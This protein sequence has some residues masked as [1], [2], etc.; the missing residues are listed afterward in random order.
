[1]TL[2]ELIETLR[3]YRII[4]SACEITVTNPETKRKERRPNIRL[5]WEQKY[6]K[7][8]TVKVLCKEV[9][10]RQGAIIDL[11]VQQGRYTGTEASYITPITPHTEA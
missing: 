9:K 3:R 5:H 7:Q 2:L 8:E 10:A 1:M 6:V 4:L 11:L